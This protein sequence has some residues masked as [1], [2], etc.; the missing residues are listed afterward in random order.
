MPAQVNAYQ[1]YLNAKQSPVCPIV[2]PS[3]AQGPT[4]TPGATGVSTG[5]EYYFHTTQAGGYSGTSQPVLNFAG[6]FPI[7]T[8]IGQGPVGG[9]P[10]QIPNT[11]PGYG[12]GTNGYFS[13][14]NGAGYVANSGRIADFRI[15]LTG[16]ATIPAGSWNFSIQAKTFITDPTCSCAPSDTTINI[17]PS[18]IY[19]SGATG[20]TL[21]TGSPVA[22]NNTDTVT[23][24][25]IFTPTTIINN[26]ATDHVNI[27]FNA[28]TP[29]AANQYIQF[30]SNGSKI[31]QVI[32][33]FP[34]QNGSTGAPGPPG[35]QG[36]STGLE[37]YFYATQ[38]GGYSGTSQPLLNNKGPTGFGMGQVPKG[39]PVVN[40]VYSPTGIYNG[41]FAYMDA[42]GYAS[43][44]GTVA[45][46]NL[47]LAG[48]QSIPAGSWNFSN[49]VYT[50]TV[51]AGTYPNPNNQTAASINMYPTITY[52]SGGTGTKIA[53]STKPVAIGYTDAP[54]VYSLYTQSS[55]PVVNPATD[56]LNFNFGLTGPFA[57]NQ[58]VE[59]WTNGDSIANV[60]TPFAPQSGPTGPQGPTGSQGP[61]GPPGT[62]GTNGTNGIP[63]APGTNGT[64]GTNGQGITGTPTQVAYYGPDNT[65]TG[66]SNFTFDGNTLS[67]PAGGVQFDGG[68]FSNQG[69]IRSGD[70]NGLILLGGNARLDINDADTNGPIRFL[71]NGSLTLPSIAIGSL[72]ASPPIANNLTGNQQATMVIAGWRIS[73]GSLYGSW[74]PGNSYPGNFDTPFGGI[75]FMVCGGQV[76]GGARTAYSVQ[77]TS[78]STFDSFANNPVTNP[79]LGGMQWLAIGP[80]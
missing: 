58:Y 8:R 56:Y 54:Y 75:P 52:W 44:T 35:P 60:I 68:P 42:S 29:L 9:N 1:L 67:L 2:G 43:N 69:Y 31:S 20:T 63:G 50:F 5:V 40:P 28:S 62:P 53:S 16:Y 14:M 64:N 23:T 24:F 55:T 26:P 37:Y 25:S 11:P 66:S 22:I 4:G 46:F 49:Q 51:P 59:F 3:G 33:P 12:V 65:A 27:Q 6:T 79:V 19:Y 15:P 36:I 30:W 47:P 78:I 10:V 45:S 73:W 61:T 70:P 77:P 76:N 21:R 32:T 71:M 74:N 38:T 48:F 18:I 7:D 80:A 72:S 41:Y 17:I 57:A 13:W 39:G 34:P